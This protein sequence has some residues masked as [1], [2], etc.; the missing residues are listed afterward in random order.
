MC[1]CWVKDAASYLEDEQ[2]STGGLGKS[3]RSPLPPG[4]GGRDSDRVQGAG[5]QP[6]GRGCCTH[7]AQRLGLACAE[8][9]QLGEE[10]LGFFLRIGLG[11]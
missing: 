9:D 5:T 4:L 7:G 2:R 10:K 6:A 1:V 8:P 3:E 11:L